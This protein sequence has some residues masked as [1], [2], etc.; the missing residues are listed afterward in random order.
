M[1]FP[2]NSGYSWGTPGEAVPP[3]DPND[4]KR[5]VVFLEGHALEP[6]TRQSKAPVPV[7]TQLGQRLDLHRSLSGNPATGL[8]FPSSVGMPINLDALT[9]NTIVPLVMKAGVRWQGWH[10]FR[11]GLATNLHRLGIFDKTI[12]KILRHANVSVTQSCYIKTADS[13][14]AEAM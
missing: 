13:E 3:I 7:I 8:M 6:K 14:V 4:L 2:D 11:R 1:T 12:Q 9:A 10:A 5:V